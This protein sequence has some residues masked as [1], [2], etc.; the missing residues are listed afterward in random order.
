MQQLSNL[1]DCALDPLSEI[2]FLRIIG[3]VQDLGILFNGRGHI[4]IPEGK[5]SIAQILEVHQIFDCQNMN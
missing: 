2:D 4:N 1:D 3:E 5:T